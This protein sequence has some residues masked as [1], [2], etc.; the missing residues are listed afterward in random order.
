M[1]RRILYTFVLLILFTLFYINQYMQIEYNINLLEYI[2]RLKGITEE[3]RKWL[4]EH[5]SIIYGAD[6]NSPPLRY[7][8]EET[9]QYQGVVVD[10][11]RAL[12]IELGVDIRVEPL[13]WEEA[14][15]SL[16][17][18]KTDMC[19][20]FPSEQRAKYYDFSDPVYNLR[21]IILTHKDENSIYSYKDLTGK[22]VAIP[23]GD[24]GVEFLKSKVDNIDFVFT[25]DIYNA[26]KLIEK[27]KVDAVVGDEP[28]ISY[29]VDKMGLKEK[30]KILGNYL[31]EKDV[32]F[33]VPKSEKTLLS[34]INKG[35]NSLKQ[36]ETM[37]K[38]QQ[39]WFG[40][41]AP[42]AK[43][44]WSNKIGLIISIFFTIVILL[45]YLFYS[46]NKFLQRE[47]DRRTEE[48][49]ISK[50]DLQ[51]TFDALTHLMIVLDKQCKV[52]NV[53]KAFCNLLGK[54][55]EEILGMNF[56][57][58]CNQLNIECHNCFIKETILNNEHY[59]REVKIKGKIYQIGTYPIEDKM[60][61]VQKVLIMIKDITKVRITEQQLLYSSKMAAIG[62]LAAGVAHEIRNPLGLIRNYSYILRNLLK[63]DD[64]K[65]KKALKIIDTSVEK[66]SNIID[67]LLNFSR[68]SG[69]IW[70]E[71]NIR[72]LLDNILDLERKEM[73]KRNIRSKIICPENMVLFINQESLKHILIN[74][75]SNAIDAM[76]NGGVLVLECYI[77][78][79]NL[80]IVCSDTGIGINS[81]DIENIFNPFFTTKPRGKGTGLG[82]YITYN[83]VKKLGGDIR[84]ESIL[85]KGT[86]FYLTIPLKEENSYE[87]AK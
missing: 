51:T 68:I 29:F 76:C 26:I 73:E 54:N 28:V 59:E 27:G 86:T 58:F 61:R 81:E 32:V 35:I 56:L 82:L 70:E 6:Q 41:S 75:I 40:I 85:D 22:K 80:H 15:K 10:Y 83:E 24:Y 62:Q 42:V 65:T 84:V 5:G 46:W 63:N 71:I 60:K 57:R 52:L 79:E 18:G 25:S 8:D 45:T 30:L 43:D 20:M 77:K 74:L 39:K 55:K 44:N 50:N 53:N 19:D 78:D 1:K 33:A 11:I 13:V 34:I 48:L 64:M 23:K 14:L 9:D 67:N 37:V 12:S 16:A 7:V 31:Y 72:D 69:N 21:G 3:E 36:K 38:I 2:S 87:Q 49:Y 66:A 4:S 47:V 17:E